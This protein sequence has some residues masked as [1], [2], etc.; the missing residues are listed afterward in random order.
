LVFGHANNYCGIEN[1]H[2]IHDVTLL[3]EGGAPAAA[4]T[5]HSKIYPKSATPLGSTT[6]STQH[7][8]KAASDTACHKLGVKPSLRT[9]R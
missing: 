5:I 9:P 2:F 7:S 1:P 4:C 6:F 8:R 3:D